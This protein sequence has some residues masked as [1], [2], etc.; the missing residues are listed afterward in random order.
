M[1]KGLQ[2][3]V[4]LLESHSYQNRRKYIRKQIV[5]VG[6]SKVYPIEYQHMPINRKKYTEV[7][8]ACF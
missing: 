5:E 7:M 8:H 1:S 3:L 4:V 6:D 2:I